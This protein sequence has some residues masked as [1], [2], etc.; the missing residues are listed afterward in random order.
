MLHMDYTNSLFYGWPECDINCL[1][2]V[3]NCA[4]KMVFNRSKYESCIQAFIDLHWLP[5]RQWTKHKIL[6]LMFNCINKTAPQYL[7]DLFHWKEAGRY[8]LWSENSHRLLKI[9]ATKRKPFANHSF[10]AVGPELWSS[11]PDYL[12]LFPQ[13]MNSRRILEVTF[14]DKLLIL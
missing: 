1:Q 7:I 2:R 11:L 9:P 14:S 4:A 10:S 12:R 8:N 5:I 13:L 3:Q 6:L